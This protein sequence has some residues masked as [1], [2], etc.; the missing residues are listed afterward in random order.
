MRLNKFQIIILIIIFLTS[1][2]LISASDFVAEK[3]FSRGSFRCTEF[4]VT[5]KYSS[6]ENTQHESGDKI[7]LSDCIAY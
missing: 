4:F 2:V 6:D 5:L 3:D 1:I 7:M